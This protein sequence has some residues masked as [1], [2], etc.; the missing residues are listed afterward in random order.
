MRNSHNVIQNTQHT[1]T[2]ACGPP[3]SVHPPLASSVPRWKNS[4]HSHPKGCSCWRQ[5][6]GGSVQRPASTTAAGGH[7]TRHLLR[8]RCPSPRAQAVHSARADLA[9]AAQRKSKVLNASSMGRG[10]VLT[11][12]LMSAGGAWADRASPSPWGRLR[13]HH[14]FHRRALRHRGFQRS[15]MI[16]KEMCCT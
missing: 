10:R 13:R 4:A 11:P 7:S 3:P 12:F 2:L 1:A 5:K 8:L 9:R 14:R 16:L 6:Q 15:L